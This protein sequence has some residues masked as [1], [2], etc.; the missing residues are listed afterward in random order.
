LFTFGRSFEKARIDPSLEPLGVG[1]LQCARENWLSESEACKRIVHWLCIRHESLYQGTTQG[2]IETIKLLILQ[3]A[4][5]AR[6]AGFADW[7]DK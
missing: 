7:K 5:I 3:F 4:R 2:A 1:G 6:F